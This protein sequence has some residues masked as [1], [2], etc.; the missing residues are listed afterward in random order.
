MSYCKKCGA[1]LVEGNK[2]CK[3]CGA[4]VPST[5]SNYYADEDPGE[6]Q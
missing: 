1:K 2:F 5:Q 4:P 6:T 3:E